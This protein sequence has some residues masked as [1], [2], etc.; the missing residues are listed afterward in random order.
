[1]KRWPCQD[2]QLECR[3]YDCFLSL[4]SAGSPPTHPWTSTDWDSRAKQPGQSTAAFGKLRILDSHTCHWPWPL[5]FWV[6]FFC[7]LACISMQRI[8]SF[9]G[10]LLHGP[11][12]LGSKLGSFY[13][14][15]EIFWDVVG[16]VSLPPHVS[17]NWRHES[18]WCLCKACAGV[19]GEDSYRWLHFNWFPLL[20]F[21]S[22]LRRIEIF[23]DTRSEGWDADW[24]KSGSKISEYLLW[25][26]LLLPSLRSFVSQLAGS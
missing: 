25:H 23:P 21:G 1:M 24:S 4:V 7:R 16:R 2:M 22:L 17:S 12:F 14:L 6:W 19:S 15:L 11:A 20:S 9:S 8:V 26:L 13:A 10:F 3:I 18:F 5:C